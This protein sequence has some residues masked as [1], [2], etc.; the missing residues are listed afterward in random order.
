MSR[1]Y[2]IVNV[3]GLSR[4]RALRSWVVQ[5]R[6]VN[7]GDVGGVV[8][9]ERTLSQDGACWIFS[10]RLDNPLVRVGGDSVVNIVEVNPSRAP[11]VNIFGT[12]SLDANAGLSFNVRNL[13]SAS[14]LTPG[15]ME[16]G[17]WSGS[18]GQ[19]LIKVFA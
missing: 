17:G 16:Q 10:G 15:K 19:P 14:P 11:F 3:G 8:F 1:K 7:V 2:E 12:S 13:S 5:G 18:A 6:Q 9:D 4:V